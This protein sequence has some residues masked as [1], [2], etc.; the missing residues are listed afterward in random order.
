MRVPAIRYLVL[1][2][3]LCAA[4]CLTLGSIGCS[5]S[6]SPVNVPNDPPQQDDNVTFTPGKSHVID[7]PSPWEGEN[8]DL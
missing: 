7:A 1:G 5:S 6:D 3:L 4:L 2:A 8:G